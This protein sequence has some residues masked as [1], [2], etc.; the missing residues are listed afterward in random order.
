LVFNPAAG[1]GRVD[2]LATIIAALKESFELRVLTTTRERD[3]DACA[4]EALAAG[5]EV[6]IAAGGDGTI[7]SVASVLVGTEAALG[8]VPH[9]TCSS[10]ARALAI[11]LELDAACLNVARGVVRRIDTAVCNGKTM[12]LN[13]AIGLHAD[14]I[15]ETSREA[16]NRFGVFAYLATG[17]D[18]LRSLEPFTLT[19]E[20]ESAVVRC[21]ATAVTVANLAP[22][23]TVLAQGPSFISPDDGLLDAT[24]VS[25]ASLFDAVTAGLHLWKTALDGDPA[26]REDIGYLPARKMVLRSEP[27]QRL[28]ID[29]EPAGETPVLLECLPQSLRVIVPELE[30]SER[31]PEVKLDGLPDLKVRLK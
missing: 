18:A 27:P 12:I 10:I 7:S 17:L 4:K 8:I 11:P 24:V 25:S 28:V 23:Q 30:R 20:T 5:A 1:L 22:P 9:G 15:S 21:R 26:T 29:G 16:K 3:G 31:V 13:A 6:V 19:M 14:V 2:D